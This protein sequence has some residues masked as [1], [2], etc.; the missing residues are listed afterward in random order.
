MKRVTVV[1]VMT[2]TDKWGE[3]AGAPSERVEVIGRWVQETTTR[4]QCT[5]MASEGQ[6]LES[7]DG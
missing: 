3:E 5:L 7:G 2:T 4:T 6:G 1:K